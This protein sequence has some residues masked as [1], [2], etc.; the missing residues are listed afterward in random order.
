MWGVTYEQLMNAQFR[1]SWSIIGSNLLGSPHFLVDGASNQIGPDFDYDMN[2]GALEDT[3]RRPSNSSSSGT[4]QST[5][6]SRPAQFFGLNDEAQLL[7]D[8]ADSSGSLGGLPN[9]IASGLRLMAEETGGER[10]GAFA[11][12]RAGR[13]RPTF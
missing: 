10:L 5:S 3:T 4:E 1:A 2:F 13:Y 7:R 12:W 6:A 11:G 8:L 9:G